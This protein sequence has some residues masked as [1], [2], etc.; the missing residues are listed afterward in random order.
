MAVSISVVVLLGI[1]VFVMIR[2]GW[3]RL[4][5]ALACA[6]FGFYLASTGVAPVIRDALGA[7]AGWIASI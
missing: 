3:V 5:P 6:G 1:I 7:V 4:W 2:S